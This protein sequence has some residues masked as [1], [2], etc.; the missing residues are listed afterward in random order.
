M[1]KAPLTRFGEWMEPMI[2]GLIRRHGLALGLAFGTMVSVG[3]RSNG[4]WNIAIF[5]A[6]FA[7]WKA[8]MDPRV[9]AKVGR[10]VDV[11][12][13]HMVERQRKRLL[14][15][16]PA[17]WVARF[18]HVHEGSKTRILGHATLKDEHGRVLYQV[19]I[20]A[21]AGQF[22]IEDGLYQIRAFVGI[23]NMAEPDKSRVERAQFAAVDGQIGARIGDLDE[24]AP[25]IGD[26][27]LHVDLLSGGTTMDSYAPAQKQGAKAQARALAHDSVTDMVVRI[28]DEALRREAAVIALEI[29]T[30]SGDELSSLR[31]KAGRLLHPDA[32]KATGASD[33][34]SAIN[35]RIDDVERAKAA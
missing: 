22:G 13:N 23:T 7:A 6:L 9:Q 14:R 3:D 11:A 31:R 34:L 20:T 33:A 27:W 4:L 19:R 24:H 10:G 28:A 1:K 15:Q 35:A 2:V 8:A 5:A 12:W 16:G 25:K 18:P 32:T 21:E 26:R 17:A 29:E 30:A